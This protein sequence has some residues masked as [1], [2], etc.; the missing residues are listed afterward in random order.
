MKNSKSVKE[1]LNKLLPFV[2]K[3]QRYLGGE[4]E[5]I[6]KNN[7]EITSNIAL[8]FPDIYEIGFSNLGLS[9][10]YKA[11]ND[12]KGLCAERAYA[13]WDDMRTLMVENKLPLYSVE[14]FKPLV[15]FSYVGFTLQYEISYLTVL[16]MLRLSNIPVLAKDR[17][18]EHPLVC[19]GGPCCLNPTPLSDFMD[20]VIIGDGEEVLPEIMEKTSGNNLS[21][22]EK[23]DLISKIDGIYIPNKEYK[24]FKPARVKELSENSRPARMIPL[25]EVIQNKYSVEVMRGCSRGCRFCSAGINYRP[26][27][28]KSKDLAIKEIKEGAKN[29]I[30][31]FSFLSLS[32]A[33]YKPITNLAKEARKLLPEREVSFMLPSTRLDAT[34]E[35]LFDSLALSKRSGITLA[36]EAGSQ[37]MRDI[38]NKGL[39]EK[40]IHDS[41][42]LAFS[43]GYSVVKLYFMIGLPWETEKDIDGII[44]LVNA[45]RPLL[46]MYKKSEIHVSISPFS[47]KPWTPFQWTGMP[48][49]EYITESGQ[50]IKSAL[51]GGRV[52]TDWRNGSITKLETIL[53]RSGAEISEFLQEASSKL[54]LQQWNE[55][56]NSELWDELLDKHK[57]DVDFLCNPVK[58]EQD[59][60]WDS[61]SPGVKKEWLKK[62][63]E[64]AKKEA[65][66][67]DCRTSKCYD[68]GVCGGGIIN[69]FSENILLE[70]TQV[71]N[72]KHNQNDYKYRIYFKKET[73]VKYIPHHDLI[74][75]FE[76]AFRAI[77]VL[78]VYSEGFSPGPRISIH[79]PLSL[80]NTGLLEVLDCRLQHQLDENI[81]KEINKFLPQGLL[82]EDY[83]F[84][85]EKSVFE[86]EVTFA[87]YK[88]VGLSEEV[89]EKLERLESS[90][91]WMVTKK[92]KRGR[93]K[94]V[95]IR[96]WF[97]SYK[98]DIDFIIIKLA[99]GI[100]GTLSPSLLFE[101]AFEMEKK[102]YLL[103]K[104]ERL[105]VE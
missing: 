102:E 77:G 47:P 42:E 1:Q 85:K 11:V 78:P 14:S 10:L 65:F 17:T 43:K 45:Q 75:L 26:V 105:R 34:N 66:T 32:T 48:S 58:L 23:L 12:K 98:K 68:C 19:A 38:I 7:K 22:K 24:N 9:I 91:E 52:K 57:I 18:E 2:E 92:A 39:T 70:E 16:D 35:E 5:S 6:I 101:K 104:Q 54:F 53:A 56:F 4:I 103:L 74:R 44:S 30:R 49:I 31:E 100:N 33:D 84:M 86:K 82:I 94:E 81:I 76:T 95:N 72:F 80:G 60:P 61:I 89:I 40:E 59:F 51:R 93:F 20:F 69:T 96:P 99:I 36:P 71:Q 55:N 41:I 62:E 15:D 90:T 88:I 37:R 67:D 87:E 13:P 63:Y 64:L 73:E 83:S 79:F 46:K 3:P 8:C 27:R 50:K 97:L 21:K 28:E 29:G 25:L